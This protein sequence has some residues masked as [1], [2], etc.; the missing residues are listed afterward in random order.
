MSGPTALAR[1]GHCI[2]QSW[3]EDHHLPPVSP[4]VSNLWP[5]SVAVTLST[6]N[7]FFNGQHISTLNDEG[8]TILVRIASGR[9]GGVVVNATIDYGGR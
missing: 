8:L 3:T 1:L 7:S 2:H 5:L 6:T 4:V 9:G